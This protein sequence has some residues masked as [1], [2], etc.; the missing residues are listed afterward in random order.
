MRAVLVKISVVCSMLSSPAHADD[1]LLKGIIVGVIGAA[2]AGQLNGQQSTKKSTSGDGGISPEVR[3]KNKEIQEALNYFGFEVGTPDGLL[4][5]KSRTAISQFQACIGRPISGELDSFTD[6]F[7]MSSYYRAQAN[8]SET[9]R[10]VATNSNGYCGLLQQFYQ[11]LT[12]PTQSTNS[13]QSVVAISSVEVNS[14]VVEQT[15]T[16]NAQ[17]NNTTTVVIIDEDIQQ[18]YDL[19]L[20]QFKL[21]EQVQKHVASKSSIASQSRKLENIT[22]HLDMLSKAIKSV[23][24]DAESKYGTPI[25]PSNANLGVT[26]AK[27]SEVFP[28]VPYYIPGTTETGELWIKPYVTNAGELMYDF[29]FVASVSDFEKVKDTIE[30]TATN[31]RAVSEALVKVTEW[32]DKA[33]AQGLRRNYEKSAI[34]FPQ[35]MCG[36]TE[37]GNNSAEVYFVI[38][39]DGSTAARLQ[40]NKGKFRSTYNL[41]IESG[42]LLAAYM[43]Y[44]AEIGENEF[45]SNTMTDTDLDALFQD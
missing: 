23:E 19:M 42:L 14:N 34:C 33:V 36:K 39:E 29:N 24:A 28:R 40:E 4:G 5:K 37:P 45:Q 21:I 2:I 38:Y 20:A 17:T 18:K 3:A 15:T 6:Q 25:R 10:I 1:R 27:A 30:M 22:D 16:I 41:S 8:P 32:S 12:N 31:I 7:L 13:T 11:E 43:D 44:M 26:A 35:Q 9:L